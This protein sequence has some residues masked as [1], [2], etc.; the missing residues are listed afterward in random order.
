MEDESLRRQST[1]LSKLPIHM[2][3]V[4]SDNYEID[5]SI[6]LMDGERKILRDIDDALQRMEDGNYGICD[7]KEEPIPVARL[8]AIPWTRYCVKC[9]ELAEKGTLRGRNTKAPIFDFGHAEDQD[10]EDSS[11]AKADKS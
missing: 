2:A 3:D 7:G 9:A 8:E 10:D 1:D 11:Y 5:N 6:G 4:G